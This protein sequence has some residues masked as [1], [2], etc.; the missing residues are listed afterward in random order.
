MK[1]ISNCEGKSKQWKLSLLIYRKLKVISSQSDSLVPLYTGWKIERY[2]LRK[3]QACFV[4]KIRN[5][6][7]PHFTSIGNWNGV[8]TRGSNFSYGERMDDRWTEA[9]HTKWNY[10]HLMSQNE[11]SKINFTVGVHGSH[12]FV[13]KWFWFL[14]YSRKW[15]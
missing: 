2:F 5:F 7:E 9:I 4:S 11:N 15:Y 8:P 12:Y 14:E 10:C 6:M 3:L 13:I 1:P